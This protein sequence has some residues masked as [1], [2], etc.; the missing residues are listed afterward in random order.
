MKRNMCYSS[1]DIKSAATE[2]KGENTVR[3]VGRIKWFRGKAA[4]S[5]EVVQSVVLKLSLDAGRASP[6]PTLIWKIDCIG[7]LE[8][9]ELFDTCSKPFKV[10]LRMVTKSRL[11]V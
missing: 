11:V 7:M 3:L 2:M 6:S 5:M 9:S 10:K 8:C 1:F 4:K